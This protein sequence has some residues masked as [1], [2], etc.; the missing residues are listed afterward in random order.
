MK[1]IVLGGAGD[2]GSQAVET[3]ARHPEVRQITIADKNVAGA[4]ALARGLAGAGPRIVVRPVDARSHS[5]VIEALRGH[6]VAASA[7]GPFYRFEAPLVRAAI[8]A[9]VDYISICDDWIAAKQVVEELDGLARQRGRRIVIGLGTSPGLSNLAAA[10]MAR[11]MD[12]PLR[13][14]ITV[15]QPP[16][17]GHGMAVLQHVLFIYG[18]PAPVWRNGRLEMVRAGR[19]AREVELPL[20]CRMQVWNAGHA[21]PVTLPRHFPTLEE[22]T[23][24]MSVGAWTYLF[25]WLGRLR[26]TATPERI[27]RV[28]NVLARL[29][30]TPKEGAS[31]PPGALRVDVEGIQGG[32]V[33]HRTLCGVGQM[34][35]ATGVPLALG[36]VMLA[37][38]QVL[39]T[40]GGVYGPEGVIDPVTLLRG[41]REETGLQAYT[42][43]EMTQPLEV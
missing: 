7:L 30:P 21:E 28:A 32:Q 37:R 12:R 41:L 27:D 36:A 25:L 17:S 20:V 42:D 9:G 8:E 5:D 23:F 11:Q 10:H 16:E 18:G 33:V 13:V 34:R 24:L 14:T 1:I 4:E 6:D 2:M 19:I 35:P 3:L 22:V 39:T 40:E 26:L 43:V 31:E 29:L 15:Y 38:G